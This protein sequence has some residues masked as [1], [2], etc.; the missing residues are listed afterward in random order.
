MVSI[1]NID[2]TVLYLENHILH[3]RDIIVVSIII[4]TL[5]GKSKILFIQ[6]DIL[7]LVTAIFIYEMSNEIKSVIRFQI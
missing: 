1:F 3:K 5:S 6:G 7:C 4:Y 2:K